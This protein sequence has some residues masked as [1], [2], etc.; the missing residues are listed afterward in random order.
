[1]NRILDIIVSFRRGL[2][3][4][5]DPAS[6][7][8]AAV[9]M[10]AVIVLFLLILVMLTFL[11]LT[12]FT[13][14]REE[15]IRRSPAD[16]DPR[17]VRRRVTAQ[18]VS[19]VMLLVAALYGWNYSASNEMCVRCHYVE[20]AIESH[21][22]GSHAQVRC[23][24]CHVGPGVDGSVLARV[25]GLENLV[26]VISGRGDPAGYASANVTNRSCL[27]CHEDIA[28]GVLLARSVRMR[29]V[30]LL[31]IGHGCIDCHNTEGHGTSVR[32]PAYPRMSMCIG[33]H[34]GTRAS[35]ECETCHSE[36]VGVAIRR[37]KRPFAQI[38]TSREDCRGCHSIVACNECHGLELPHSSQFIAGFHARKAFLE[39]S[40]CLRCHD[41]VKFCNAC[42]RFSVTTVGATSWPRTHANVG[43]FVSW[44]A[45]TPAV[46]LGSCLCH[47]D[48]RQRFCNNCHGP[49]PER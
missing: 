40:V 29:H 45:N 30:E 49:Q 44:H 27:T 48:D 19:A 7:P 10:L 17:H 4:L 18:A 16:K 42:H 6:N 26:K 34:D 12:L 28:Q 31:D 36:D 9:F 24:A 23:K 8:I 13:G 46:G 33:C 25:R 43:P 20:R 1:M 2:E 11:A 39:P 37:L 5:A 15:P 3:S 38:T 32:K 14:A 47:D 22:S 41:V 21:E 35:A